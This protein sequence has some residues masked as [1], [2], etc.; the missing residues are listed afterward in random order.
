VKQPVYDL[1]LR[2]FR[3]QNYT[4]PH[5]IRAASLFRAVREFGSGEGREERVVIINDLKIIAQ[6]CEDEIPVVLTEDA[7]TL[8]RLALRL[9]KTGVLSV[10]ALLLASGFMPEQLGR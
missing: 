2:S 6:A 1:P 8:S 5:A 3:I 9:Q 10:S 4:L 7:N